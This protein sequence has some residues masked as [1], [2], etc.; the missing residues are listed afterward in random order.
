MWVPGRLSL[1]SENGRALT[2]RSPVAVGARGADRSITNEPTPDGVPNWLFLTNV[3]SVVGIVVVLG[4][5][6]LR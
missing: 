2:P 4:L 1:T 3:V 6:L 5:S